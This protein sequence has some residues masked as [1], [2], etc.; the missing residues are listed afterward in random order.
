MGE[1]AGLLAA[2]SL[3]EQIGFREIYENG[4]ALKAFQQYL[5]AEGIPLTWEEYDGKNI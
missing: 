2:Y 4:E 1:A 5:R 3:R